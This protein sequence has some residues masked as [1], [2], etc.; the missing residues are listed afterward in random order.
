MTQHTQTLLDAALSYAAR[1][2]RV[3]PCHTPTAV[4]SSCRKDCGKDRGKHPRTEHGFKDATTDEATLRRWW[5][6]F[7][8]ANI[9]I[10]TGAISGLAVLDEDSYKGGDETRRDLERCYQPL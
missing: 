3:F 7:P 5:S 2:W 10:V 6:Q 8:D 1:G 4:G 9:G